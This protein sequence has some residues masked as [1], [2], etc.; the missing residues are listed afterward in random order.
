[1]HQVNPS[2]NQAATCVSTKLRR[3]GRG[4]GTRRTIHQT[5]QAIAIA[6]PPLNPPASISSD[7]KPRPN[8]MV[9]M[10]G[11]TVF[12]CDRPVSHSTYSTYHSANRH[13]RRRH[14][15]ATLREHSLE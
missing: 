7:E 6:T 1:M 13:S 12:V 5:T 10:I 4:Q 9:I 15:T 11:S 8:L 2:A 14:V 3:N